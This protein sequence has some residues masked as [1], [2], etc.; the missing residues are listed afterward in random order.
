MVS[1][2]GEVLLLL[3]SH[4]VAGVWGTTGLGD[5]S[6]SYWGM[7]TAV[8]LVPISPDWSRLSVSASAPLRS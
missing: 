4:V 3:R 7:G 2:I 8:T 5:Q 6:G 1:S